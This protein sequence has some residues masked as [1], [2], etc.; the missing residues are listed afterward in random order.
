L[1]HLNEEKEEEK[2]DSRKKE[3]GKKEMAVPWVDIV[4]QPLELFVKTVFPVVWIDCFQFLLVWTATT[5]N[6]LLLTSWTVCL[7]VIAFLFIKQEEEAHRVCEFERVA[8]TGDLFFSDTRIH[9]YCVYI[10]AIR[11]Y[12]CQAIDI[13]KWI[14]ALNITL[15]SV[16]I[17][18]LE[19]APDRAPTCFLLGIIYRFISASALT[20]VIL[21]FLCKRASFSKDFSS[22][23]AF[24]VSV[25][26]LLVDIDTREIETPSRI[27]ER[28][29]ESS[30][31]SSIEMDNITHTPLH[32]TYP[33]SQR[34]SNRDLGDHGDDGSIS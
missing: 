24:A 30:S 27:G 14:L 33:S 21:F 26:M 11:K 13:T 25:E 19:R 1:V 32:E 29:L 4:S 12:A 17:V 34:Y 20:L 9:N 16:T 15:L 2:T 8:L 18:L 23:I 28:Q 31:S 3:K 22:D 5:S 7:L 6:I 10:F